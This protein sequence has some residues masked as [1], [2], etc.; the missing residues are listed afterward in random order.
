MSYAGSSNM[1]KGKTIVDYYILLYS[2]TLY[3]ATTTIYS[4]PIYAVKR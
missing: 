1:C 3:L 4:V 2:T